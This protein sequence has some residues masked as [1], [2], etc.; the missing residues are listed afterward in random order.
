MPRYNLLKAEISGKGFNMSLEMSTDAIDPVAMINQ[1]RRVLMVNGFQCV[2][3]KTIH[4]NE[5]IMETDEIVH[6]INV[7]GF[8]ARVIDK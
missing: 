6:A 1:I 7:L 5:G 2:V 4:F 8:D 3:W